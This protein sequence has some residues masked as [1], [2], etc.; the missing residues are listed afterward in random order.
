MH[1]ETQTRTAVPG[2]AEAG[3]EEYI[4]DTAS[5]L[6]QQHVD[7]LE[8]LLDEPTTRVLQGAGTRDGHRCLEVG[9]GGGSIARW[10][11]ERAGPTGRVVAVDLATDH[12]GGSPDIDVRHWDIH[13]G[14]PEGG[15]YDLIH[16]RLVLAHLPRRRELLQELVGALAPGGWLVLGEMS[17]RPMKVLSAPSDSD[18]ALFTYMQHLSLDVVSPARGLSL[19]WADELP[20]QMASA[21][22]VD[23]HG[24]QHSETSRGGDP[25]C[26]LHRNLNLQAEPLLREEGATTT[27]LARYREL[28]LDPSFVA[29]FFQFVCFRG[30]R[31][32]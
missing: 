2:A 16:A 8:H 32:V 27:Q 24:L 26:L 18:A 20:G 15:P 4:F 13:D 19:S 7:L 1:D 9:A 29:W 25:G 17:D 5:D 31:P 22:L 23:L 6:G 12:M 30:R 21:G 14:I 28:L 3:P 10:L 11:A